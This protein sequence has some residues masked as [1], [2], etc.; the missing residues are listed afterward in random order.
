[1]QKD[2]GE[3]AMEQNSFS[4][5]HE[6]FFYFEGRVVEVD[7]VGLKVHIDMNDAISV[8]K[9]PK[10]TWLGQMFPLCIFLVET[11]SFVSLLPYRDT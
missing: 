1:M 6:E 5:F 2:E 3:N 4:V 7:V 11:T 10:N 8:G 9:M